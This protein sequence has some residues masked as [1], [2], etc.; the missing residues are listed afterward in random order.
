MILETKLDFQEHHNDKL[1][2]I[3]KAIGLLRKLQKILT[4]TPLLRGEPHIDFR[5][6]CVIMTQTRRPSLPLPQSH[7]QIFDKIESF[8]KPVLSIFVLHNQ[9]QGG[10]GAYLGESWIDLGDLLIAGGKRINQN[11]I[12]VGIIHD[13]FKYLS[14]NFLQKLFPAISR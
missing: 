9:F 2:N 5:T 6:H 4:R 12:K 3:S 7:S 13:P 10:A 8:L 14:Q 1:S 11:R